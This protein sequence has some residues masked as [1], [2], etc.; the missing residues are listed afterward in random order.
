MKSTKKLP[1]IITVNMKKG[2]VG[3]T[4]VARLI[5][6]YLAK[7]A[8]T[9]LIDADE[10]SNTTKRTNVDRSHNQQAELE[11]IFQK[12]IVE[13]V[14]IQENLDLVLGTANLEQVNVDLA[15]KFN[16]TIKFL[17]Y[18][19]KQPTFREYEYLVID[20]RNDTNIITNNMLVAADLVLGVCDTCADSYDEWLNLLEHMDDLREEVIDDM[21]EESYVHA[22]VK[23]VGNKVSPKTNVSKQFKEVM[24]EDEDCLGYI[25]NRAVFDEAI[26]LRKSLL[27][28]IVNKPN[29]DES[30]KNFVSNTLSLLS[31]IK[32][33]VDNE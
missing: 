29:Q 1:K 21:T 16:N 22:K 15:S 11:N 31:E 13:P 20:T 9:C 7:S 24:A 8:K 28:Y 4:A 2:G 17:A 27:D 23:F 25:E 12:K 14:T 33:C 26:L 32:A 10:S 3:K 18:L 6:D 30:Y 5:A 19:K